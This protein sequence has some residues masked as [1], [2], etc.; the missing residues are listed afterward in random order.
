MHISRRAEQGGQRP[1]C[2]PGRDC[3]RSEA[4]RWCGQARK[5]Q[6]GC[7]LETTRALR[8]ACRLTGADR[9]VRRIVRAEKTVGAGVSRALPG[10]SLVTTYEIRAGA[11]GFAKSPG[12]NARP[13]RGLLC[14]FFS[15]LFL[16]IRPRP[17]QPSIRGMSSSGETACLSI[18]RCTTGAL[19]PRCSLRSESVTSASAW[20]WRSLWRMYSTQVGT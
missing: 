6:H 3:H 14:S 20:V 17:D 16:I 1:A 9:D 2:D 12:R 13:P 5:R 8:G 10:R 19:S 18:I 4:E 15:R 11:F 7:P